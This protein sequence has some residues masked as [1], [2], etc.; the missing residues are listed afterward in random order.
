MPSRSRAIENQ[1]KY[2]L[3][4]MGGAF[5]I[6]AVLW[7]FF[8]KD[9]VMA[10]LQQPSFGARWVGLM[11]GAVLTMFAMGAIMFPIM[12]A[13]QRKMDAEHGGYQISYSLISLLP[14]KLFGKAQREQLRLDTKP[15]MLGMAIGGT[16]AMRIN[17]MHDKIHDQRDNGVCE[18]CR[19]EW[20]DTY[21][22]NG[23]NK[24]HPFLFVEQYEVWYCIIPIRKKHLETLSY[25]NQHIPAEYEETLD[26]TSYN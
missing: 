20:H 25:C 18:K 17:R 13:H 14:S 23:N 2:M 12:M 8:F 6:A 1:W 10:V 7:H 4:G 5:A 16:R 15:L 3:A 22:I 26:R 19:A 9:Y 24:F 21:E 11:A